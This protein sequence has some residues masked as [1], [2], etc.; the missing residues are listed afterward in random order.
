[1]AWCR[2][3]DSAR[4]KVGQIAIA[5][6]SPYGFQHTVTAGIVSAL[7]RSMRAQTGRLLDNVL[8]TDAALNPGN[9]GGPLID[10]H[11][12][13]IGMNTA[14]ASKNG[15]NAGV[16]FA[17][18]A[19]AISRVFPE[20]IASG[21]VTRPETGISR[22]YESD[23]GLVVATLA[24]G[25]PAEQAGIRGFKIVKERKRQGPFSYETQTVDRSVADVIIAVN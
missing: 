1:L 7:G 13:V 19:G 14:I 25:G 18:P 5:I 21:H 17:I 22:V 2:F 8:Q 15:Q 12:R 9:S 4:V 16:G 11:G 6:G 10:T 23:K 20:L 24:T 3:G